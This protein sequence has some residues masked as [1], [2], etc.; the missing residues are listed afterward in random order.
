M[1][2]QK[3]YTLKHNSLTKSSSWR[4]AHWLLAYGKYEQPPYYSSKPEANE[5]WR[6]E[7]SHCGGRVVPITPSDEVRLSNPFLRTISEKMKPWNSNPQIANA[8]APQTTSTYLPSMCVSL[9]ASSSVSPWSPTTSYSRIHPD[10]RTLFALLHKTF[11]FRDTWRLIEM[12][13]WVLAEPTTDTV[14]AWDELI[15]SCRITLFS[16]IPWNSKTWLSIGGFTYLNNYHLLILVWWICLPAKTSAWCSK[17]T[18]RNETKSILLSKLCFSWLAYT[19]TP[20]KSTHY[21]LNSS[22]LPF[23]T[24]IT[25]KF[26]AEWKLRWVYVCTPSLHKL[27]LVNSSTLI[28]EHKSSFMIR[29]F[30]GNWS[31]CDFLTLVISMWNN[32][33][34]AERS[35][36]RKEDWPRECPSTKKGSV[37]VYP[38]SLRAYRN[39][40]TS[41]DCLKYRRNC[42]KS[43]DFSISIHIVLSCKFYVFY[44]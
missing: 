25:K 24:K 12:A 10:S 6:F 11:L 9:P 5:V 14:S 13:K 44:K 36:N 26:P 28:S 17:D 15:S 16:D 38:R 34:W 22:N 30:K 19:V 21:Y 4:G 7:N 39:K 3:K 8:A 23:T 37:A 1:L 35:E 42:I 18:L 20:S 31:S 2:P 41:P 29:I 43:W 33:R 32:H 40:R 27:L